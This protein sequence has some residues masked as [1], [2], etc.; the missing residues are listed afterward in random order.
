MKKTYDDVDMLTPYQFARLRTD[1]Y[2]GSMELTEQRIVGFDS[3]KL[4]VQDHSFVPALAVAFREIIDNAVDEVVGHGHGDTISIGYY[5]EG[6]VYT[7][8]DNGRGI[9]SNLVEK[10]LA[11]PMSGRNFRQRAS[12]AGKNGVGATITNYTS[13]W[14]DINACHDGTRHE[15]RFTQG[16]AKIVIGAPQITKCGKGDHG[17]TIQFKPSEQVFGK[18]TALPEAF[19]K[20][21][22]YE[23]AAAFPELK[24]FYNDVRIKLSGQMRKSLLAGLDPVV[25]FRCVGETVVKHSGQRELDVTEE[26]ETRHSFESSFYLVPM[27]DPLGTETIHSIVNGIPAYQGGTHVDAFRREFY[28]TV[29]AVL[30]R[31]AKKRKLSLDRQDVSYGVLVYNVTRMASPNFDTQS[32][33]KLVSP[34]IGK[35]IA[36]AIDEDAVKRVVKDNPEWVESI[37]KRCAAR[38][39]G[40]DLARA[41]DESKKALKARVA[42]LRDANGKDRS[43]CV[44]FIAEGDSAIGGMADVRDSMI[45]GGL[46]LRG[47]IMNAHPTAATPGEVVGSKELLDIMAAVGLQIGKK[48]IPRSALRYGAIYIATDEDE[49]GHNIMCLVV[50]FLHRFWPELFDPD[51]E[52]FVYKFD[53]PYLILEKG[54]ERKYFFGRNYSEYEP[55]NFKGWGEP[56]RAKGLGRLEER[57][58][59]DMLDKP[60][61]LPIVDDGDLPKALDLA[62]NK[63]R[64]DDRK[65]WLGRPEEE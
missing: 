64:A 36:K 25:E 52:P 7:V 18:H 6:S 46:P 62:F 3:V 24:V 34:E 30:D 19:V 15:Q 38:T 27:F 5:P 23:L 53:T 47:K 56:I 54:S 42:K 11:N 9:P 57:H 26:T 49:D 4:S 45:H 51:L 59:A 22:A 61:L 63:T 14:F 8:T 12:V 13:E 41:S 10:L 39:Q 65:E 60:S 16:K 2:F 48:A 21:R 31:E 29:I 17:T 35:A 55:E 37:F 20:A 44:L 43:K 1:V 28:G 40:K 58:W 33:A 32:K 50:N